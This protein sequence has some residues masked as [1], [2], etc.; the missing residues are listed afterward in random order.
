MCVF[1]F[2]RLAFF[3]SAEVLFSVCVSI[4][5]GVCHLNI[6]KW[7]DE[8]GVIGDLQDIKSGLAAEFSGPRLHSTI[9][10]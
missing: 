4:H 5:P 3:S 6:A 10:M 7:Q 1:I 2:F 8:N 9:C